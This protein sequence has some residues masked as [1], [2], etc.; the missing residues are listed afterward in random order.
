MLARENQCK[1]IYKTAYNS[2]L[3]VNSKAHQ[4]RNKQKLGK[5]LDVGQ[6]VLMENHSFEDGKSKK[7]HELRSGP[8]EVTKKLT[9]VNYEK[10]LVSNKTVK[11]VAHRN[12][13]IEYF[14]IG[15]AISELVVDY[16]LKN[17][18]FQP[19]YKNLMIK[20]NEKLNKPVDKFS[21]QQP[22][23]E[24]EFF[25]GDN[26]TSNTDNIQNENNHEKHLKITIPQ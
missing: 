19:F 14:P 6:L 3:E 15:N 5:L 4:N 2:S 9:N 13:L 21:F 11:K 7:L 22:Y 8:Y 12:H 20:Q 23:T 26:F 25:P 16:G 18:N 1:Q 10:E 24:T 17:E